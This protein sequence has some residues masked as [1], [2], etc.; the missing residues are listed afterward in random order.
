M[1]LE[2]AGERHELWLDAAPG[3]AGEA[4]RELTARARTRPARMKPITVGAV[5]KFTCVSPASS[6]CVAGPP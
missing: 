4:W 6:D 5:A 2:L 3:T 1:A